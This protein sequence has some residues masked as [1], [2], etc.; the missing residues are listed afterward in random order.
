VQLFAW[1]CCVIDT[2]PGAPTEARFGHHRRNS[3]DVGSFLDDLLHIALGIGLQ[4]GI[5]SK[6]LKEKR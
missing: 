6:L 5:R 3:R 2:I 4:P 1:S